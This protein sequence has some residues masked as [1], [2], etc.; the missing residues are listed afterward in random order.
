MASSIRTAK[1]I[2]IGNIASV[3]ISPNFCAETLV[4]P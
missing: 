1:N 2:Y 4:T 3:Y